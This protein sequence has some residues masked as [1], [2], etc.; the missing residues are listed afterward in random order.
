MELNVIDYLRLLRRS[1]LLFVVAVVVGVLGAAGITA[2]IKPTY[3]ATAQLFVSIQGSGSVTELN[4]G[5][6][7][8]KERVQTYVETVKTPLVLEPVIE[9]LNLDE[10]PESLA[11]KVTAEAGAN[12]VLMSISVDDE[13]PKVAAEVANA[14][15]DSLTDAVSELETPESDKSSPVQISTVE[16]ASEPSAPSSPNVPLNMGLGLFIGLGLGFVAAILRQ[17][18]DTRIRTE[19]VLQRFT[20]YPI[21]GKISHDES[22]IKK[23]LITQA[24]SQSPR[25]EAFKHLRTNLQFSRAG[26]TSR[27]LLFT[28]SLPE[29][30]KTTTSINVAISMAEAGQ[31]VLLID[32]DLRRPRVAKYLGLEG[33]VGLTTYLVGQASVHD[34]LQPWGPNQLYVLTA[35]RVPPNPSE[36]LGSEYMKQLIV[37]AGEEFDVVIIDGPP[38]LPVADSAVI[39]GLVEGVVLIV[40]AHKA[41][42]PEVERALNSLE[43]VEAEIL[44]VIMNRLSPKKA[45]TYRYTYYGVDEAN[46]RVEK[47]SSVS[48]GNGH[49]AKRASADQ[50][51]ANSEISSSVSGLDEN[52]SSADSSYSLDASERGTVHPAFDLF[53]SEREPSDVVSSSSRPRLRSPET[54]DSD[55]AG[56]SRSSSRSSYGRVPAR[57]VRR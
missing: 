36:L 49:G 37:E 26:G 20:Q 45:D 42:I 10:S 31:R 24:E 6:L 18:F 8:T 48:D 41:R 4:Q 46:E 12:T 28:S 25:V 30:G 32:G 23:P 3:T 11:S 53:G 27:S 47:S 17:L 33:S 29:E 9:K 39:S 2:L 43:L 55:E 13:S 7:F 51:E 50:A 54:V 52:L 35:G 14:V 56:Q 40:G 19:E 15:G 38:L 57:H 22:A 16:A 44:G 21:L 5:S 34:V 1:W